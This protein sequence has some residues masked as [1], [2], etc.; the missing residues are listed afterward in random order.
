MSS[1]GEDSDED[2]PDIDLATGNKDT[3]VLEVSSA[4]QR[5]IQAYRHKSRRCKNKTKKNLI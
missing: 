2:L 5:R 1:D 3:Y 4:L